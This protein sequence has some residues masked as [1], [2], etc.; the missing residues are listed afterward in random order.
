MRLRDLRM[1]QNLTQAQLGK[2]A[3]VRQTTISKLEAGHTVDPSH[4]TVTRI[5]RAL[6][7]SWSDIDE[8]EVTA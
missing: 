3:H 5:A 7:V 4:R 2:L 8:F 1:A 6:G